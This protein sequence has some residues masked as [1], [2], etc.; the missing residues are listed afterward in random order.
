MLATKPA[1][2]DEA[3]AAPTPWAH[4]AFTSGDCWALAWA[5]FQKLPGSRLLALGNTK[6][7]W[8]SHVV[9]EV[10]E[11]LYL[12]V[13]GVATSEVLF[14]RWGDPWVVE[15]WQVEAVNF[16]AYSHCLNMDDFLYIGRIEEAHEMADLLISHH[17]GGRS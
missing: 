13:E 1:L 5:I 15:F 17:L 14:S 2:W 3:E 12:D 8:W 7:Y 16:A 4:E 6:N 9:V 10:R 11:G